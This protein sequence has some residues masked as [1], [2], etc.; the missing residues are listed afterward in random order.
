MAA[1]GLNKPAPAGKQITAGPHRIL[2]GGS[3]VIVVFVYKI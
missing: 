1:A 2:P 3:A